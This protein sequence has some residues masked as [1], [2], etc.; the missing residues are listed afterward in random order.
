M[1]L[2]S[3]HPQY[4]DT[5]GLLAL[6]REGLL[7]QKVLKGKTKGY[8]KHPQLERFKNHSYSLKALGF[9]LYYIHKDGLSR[10]H[11]FNKDKIIIIPSRIRQIKVS[12]GQLLF[13]FKHLMKKLKVRDQLR[14]KKYLK[15]KRIKAHPMF[16]VVKGEIE[17]WER[18]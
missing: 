16:K 15:T 17:Q 12:R 14:Y 13:E 8:K 3:I 1:R 6:W 2:W 10:G 11:N 7:A 18:T 9:Y 4:L 5:K